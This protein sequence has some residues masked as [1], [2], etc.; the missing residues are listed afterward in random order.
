MTQPA[1]TDPDN[2]GD[3]D[4]QEA[5]GELWEPDEHPHPTRAQDVTPF[6]AKEI[7]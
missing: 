4:G 2:D 6:I 3:G 7:G 5:P 1:T